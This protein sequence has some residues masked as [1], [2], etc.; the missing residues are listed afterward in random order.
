MSKEPSMLKT[1]LAG[2]FGGA[3]LVLVG[4]PLDTIK[5]RIQTMPVVAGQP[6]AYTGTFDCAMK[7]I[8]K[9][10]P[11]GLYKGIIAPLLGVT[12][13]Y[14]LCFLG[15]GL[16]KKIFLKEDSMRNLDGE[17]LTR[18]GLAGATSGV[19]TTPIL[20]PL[21]RVKCVLQIQGASLKPGQSKADL[22][23]PGG[24]LDTATRMMKEGGIQS[25][26]RGF[27]STMLRDSVASFFYF[28]SYE[29]TK[30][31][32][33]PSDGTPM[34][35]WGFLLAGGVAGIFNWLGCLPIDTLKSKLQVAP[36]GK[37][38]NG[39]RS[40]FVEVMREN[41]FMSLYRGFIP[42]MI[43][44]FPANAAC[45]YGYEMALK[46]LTDLGIE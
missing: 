3:C 31:L 6:P 30:Y 29:Y 40:V 39:I 23:Y 10:G 2:G 46:A 17:N 45:F 27:F 15:Y 16:G 33:R 28:S 24:V 18:I 8:R 38:P 32:L 25:V 41:G 43:R 14:S 20:A 4:H 35:N 36:E 13:M 19:F 44:A 22:K 12:P 5:V 11:M 7:I 34:S 1:T 21:E 37:Y 26:N 9:E 42:V